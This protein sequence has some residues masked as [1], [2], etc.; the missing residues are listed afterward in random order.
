MRRGRASALCDW[1]IYVKNRFHRWKDDFSDIQV[2]PHLTDQLYGFRQ[3]TT[4][5]IIQCLF[6][7]NVRGG[8]GAVQ[9][10]YV[11]FPFYGDRGRQV[12]YG[13]VASLIL[14]LSGDR[15][16]LPIFPERAPEL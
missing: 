4:G 12:A 13:L 8:A 7:S 9:W 2:I 15:E 5:D 10:K 14:E 11:Q 1:E 3:V 16:N 6:V